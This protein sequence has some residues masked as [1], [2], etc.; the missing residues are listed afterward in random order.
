MSVHGFKGPIEI[1]D[2]K[3]INNL[4]ILPDY[5]GH[6]SNITELFDDPS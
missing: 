1:V 6:G 3:I 4:E 5:I 2:C